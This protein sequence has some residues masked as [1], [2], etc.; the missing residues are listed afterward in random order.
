MSGGLRLTPEEVKTLVDEL[1]RRLEERGVPASILIFGGAAMAL[2]FPDDPDVR[3]TSDI[4]AAYE[5]I[6]EVDEVVAEMARDFDLP[7]RWLNA[8]GKPWNVV[9]PSGATV[10]VADGEE[11]IAM[12]LA[13]GRAQDM[14]DLRIAARNLQIHHA[15][16]L[17][18]IAYRLYGED[19]PALGDGRESYELFAE[20]VLKPKRSRGRSG[21]QSE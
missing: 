14:A 4:D 1:E 8:P 15:N 13:A 10:T 17:V 12:K 5:P 16:E 11:L 18:D 7:D 6:A 2:R 9:R 19:S 20:D 3:T 21:A